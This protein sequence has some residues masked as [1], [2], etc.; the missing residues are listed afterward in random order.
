MLFPTF[1]FAVFFSLV[2]PLSWALR[3]HVRAW[4]LFILAAS[5]VFYGWW[6]WR[7]LA[8][9]ALVTLREPRPSP[10]PLPRPEA[11]MRHG[12]DS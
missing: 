4:K 9:I 3:A 7:F 8:L 1:T 12:S 10:S 2:L 5:Y 11:M 6:D